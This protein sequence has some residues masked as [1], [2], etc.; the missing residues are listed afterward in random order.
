MLLKANTIMYYF[1]LN[2]KGKQKKQI[3]NVSLSA[4]ELC[5]AIQLHCLPSF[6]TYIKKT[7]TQALHTSQLDTTTIHSYIRIKSN[8]GDTA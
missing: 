5:I 1:N 4:R 8:Y 2:A 7:P 6:W 3:Y